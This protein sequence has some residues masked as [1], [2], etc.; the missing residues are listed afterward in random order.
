MRVGAQGEEGAR[1]VL[2]ATV[3]RAD[4]LADPTRIETTEDVLNGTHCCLVGAQQQRGQVV[5]SV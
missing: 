4:D 3:S 1:H 2:V 5:L